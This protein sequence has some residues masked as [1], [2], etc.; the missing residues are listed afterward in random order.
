MESRGPEFRTLD[1]TKKNP[2]MVEHACHHSPVRARDRQIPEAHWPASLGKMARSGS[3][4]REENDSS[5]PLI[6]TYPCMG[7]HTCAHTFTHMCI[8]HTH[9]CMGTHTCVHNTHI[10]QL[11]GSDVQLYLAWNHRVL[12][13]GQSLRSGGRSDARPCLPPK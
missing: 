6:T 4:S 2:R 11:R 9:L 13:L 8:Q 3:V 10:R 7:T 1:P 5:L 12:Q